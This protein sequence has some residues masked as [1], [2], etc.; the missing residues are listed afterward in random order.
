[1]SAKFP[2]NYT[3]SGSFGTSQSKLPF[4]LSFH[5]SFKG[6][7]TCCITHYRFRSQ[8]LKH[9]CLP[10]PLQ[11]AVVLLFKW[12][13]AGYRGLAARTHS[14]R[15]PR[16]GSCGAPFGA[17]TGQSPTSGTG[18]SAQPGVSPASVTEAQVH[19]AEKTQARPAGVPV[20]QRSFHGE[21]SVP[22]PTLAMAMQAGAL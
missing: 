11:A 14:P 18:R 8:P 13:G 2:G 21:T 15:Q 22:Q 1:M 4:C 17:P 10:G 19:S 3:H 20:C 6:V 9:T 12:G 16:R 7:T 5:P